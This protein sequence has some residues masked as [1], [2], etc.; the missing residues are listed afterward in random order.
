ME[1]PISKISWF[2]SLQTMAPFLFWVSVYNPQCTAHYIRYFFGRQIVNV[3]FFTPCRW[4]YSS[5]WKRWVFLS[6]DDFP[7][8]T[9]CSQ[10]TQ[11]SLDRWWR[12]WRRPPRSC[13]TF[14]CYWDPHVWNWSSG[15]RSW[16]L[17]RPSL[18]STLILCK[19]TSQWLYKYWHQSKK[20]LPPINNMLISFLE[21]PTERSK[22]TLQYLS[23]KAFELISNGCIPFFSQ[24]LYKYWHQSKKGLPP[25]NNMLISFL[26]LP[27][28]RKKRF[29][30]LHI[31]SYIIYC[32]FF[33]SDY[34][35]T[36]TSLRR[37]CPL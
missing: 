27:T 16:L 22:Q 15:M 36:G 34:T 19:F 31:Y 21:L 6:G 4:S 7:F 9:I 28:E 24:W 33:L 18:S 30:H 14:L 2:S 37:V 5:H 8:A 23:T 29:L 25:I 12:W 26:E 17:R 20:G 10:G 35:N 3:Q 13:K 11:E 1:D 32:H